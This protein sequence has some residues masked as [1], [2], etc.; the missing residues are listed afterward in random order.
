MVMCLINVLRGE[1]EACGAGM[2]VLSV[3]YSSEKSGFEH[4]NRKR[5]IKII[6]INDLCL[7]NLAHDKQVGEMSQIGPILRACTGTTM[8]VMKLPMY[9]DIEIY[10]NYFIIS[11]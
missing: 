10:F 3:M 8:Q 7:G 4:C 1:L 11:N 2:S 9:K 5:D 6:A